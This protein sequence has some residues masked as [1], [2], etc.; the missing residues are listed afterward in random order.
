MQIEIHRRRV[1]IGIGGL[2][3]ATALDA[4]AAFGTTTHKLQLSAFDFHTVK[5]DGRNYLNGGT[6]PTAT[7]ALFATVPLPEGTKIKSIKFFVSNIGGSQIAMLVQKYIATS[8]APLLIADSLFASQSSTKVN[9]IHIPV[10]AVIASKESYLIVV[11]S[12]HT[13]GTTLVHGAQ[14]DYD[15]SP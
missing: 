1:L 4:G 9:A 10:G 11:E 8:A 15:P 13:D 2:T 3:A 6:Y 12:L 14:I 7:G 5:E